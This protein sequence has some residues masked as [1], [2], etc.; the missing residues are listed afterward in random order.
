MTQTKMLAVQ[1]DD[2]GT[3]VLEVSN[4]RRI[5]L[6]QS[7]ALNLVGQLLPLL[8]GACL[9][10]YLT[11]SL[12]PERFGVLGIVWLVFGYFSLFDFGLGRAT[13][14]FL[15]ERIARGDTTS[16]SELV[17]VSIVIQ[18]AL[19]L[20]GGL[21][22]LGL[23]PKLVNHVLKIPADLV[24]ETHSTFTILAITLPVVLATSG[25][26]SVLEGCQRFD[27][28]NLLR[29]PMSTLA[30]V[31]PSISVVFGLRL[32]G[33][34]SLLAL[35]RVG[36]AVAHLWLCLRVLPHL[37][38]R[39]SLRAAVVLP[40]LS[41]GGWVTVSNFINPLLVSVERFFIGS[42]LSMAMVGYYTAPFEAVTKLWIVPGSLTT[43][44]FPACS[45][46][47]ANRI[48]ELETLY[49][50]S[51]KYLFVVIAPISLILFLLAR[52]IMVVWL[53]PEFV[54]KSATV[55]QVL[56]VGVFI[57]CFAHIPYSFL[58]GLG[59]PDTAAKLF[60]AEL[61]PYG[62]LALWSIRNYGIVGAAV[63]WS[64]R[65][66][67]EVGLLTLM[68]WRI[69]ALSP[70]GLWN[71]RMLMCIVALSLMGALIVVAKIRFP[72]SLTFQVAVSAVAAMGF[73]VGIWKYVLDESDRVSFLSLLN[74]RR[75]PNQSRAIA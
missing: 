51:I 73:S 45:A 13:T 60:L 9:I 62:V 40:L 25:F 56:T 27:I 71:R 7:T 2:L 54:L 75:G 6:A 52:S 33:I 16:I 41:F 8:A 65:A 14:K 39:P 64:V 58:Q 32:P 59:R 38:S 48:L 17:W 18:V 68:V 34:V 47:G 28:S 36:F 3:N 72:I 26:R 21:V 61:F 20:L 63:A 15:A 57:N 30:F 29:I 74:V 55:M 42:V 11:R 1:E 22:L 23:T 46:L 66:G 5:G 37:K 35:S 19:G 44:I 69:L 10:P 4:R 53:G 70:R 31:I 43:A 50:R 24:V 49:T 12:G 67:L